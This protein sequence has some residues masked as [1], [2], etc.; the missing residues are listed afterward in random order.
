ME[1]LLIPETKHSPLIAVDPD[2]NIFEITGK[3]FPEDSKKIYSPLLEYLDKNKS[4]LPSTIN[5]KFNLFYISSSSIISIKQVLLK[6]K[7]IANEGRNIE[8]LWFH[9][10]DDE[11]IKKTGEDYVKITGLNFKFQVNPD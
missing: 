11:D 7:E 1:K 5:F 6:L 8:I 10:E 3:S 4:N 2:R 9:D